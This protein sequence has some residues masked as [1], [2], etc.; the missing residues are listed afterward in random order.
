[1]HEL[2]G[3]PG[4]FYHGNDE[5]RREDL[6]KICIEVI[7]DKSLNKGNCSQV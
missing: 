5:Q 7:Q 6:R 4:D 1:M 3:V 2:S